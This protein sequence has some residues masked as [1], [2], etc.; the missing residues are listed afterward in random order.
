MSKRLYLL[1][2]ILAGLLISPLRGQTPT[3]SIEG[4]VTDPN[5]ANIAGATVTVTSTTTSKSV[6]VTTNDDGFFSVRS[7]EPGVY[8]IRVERAGFS[9]ATA[10]NIV[11][12]VSQVARA[13]IQL[14]VGTPTENVNVEVGATDIQV[15]TTRQTV[16]GVI[17]GRQITALPLNERNFLDLA[18]LQPGVTVLDG[19]VIDP[20]KV[21]AYRVVRVNGGSGT[22]TRVQLE[23]IDITDEVVGTT[24]ANLSTDAVQEFNLQ[25]SSFDLSTSLTTS[26]AVT[27]ATRTGGNKFSGSGFYFK[28]DDRF[29]AR[30]GFQAVKPKFNRDQTGYRFGGP[31][32][33]DRLFFFSNFERFNQQ[34]FNDFTSRNFPNFNSGATLPLVFRYALNRVDMNITKNLRAFYL[35]NYDDDVST[36][37][38]IRSPFQNVDWTNAHVVGANVSGTRMTHTFRF[39]YVNFNNRIESQELSQFPF[40]NVN[41]TPIQV[42]VGDLSYGPNSLAPQQTYQDTYQG[43]YDGSAVLGSHVLRYGGEISRIILGGFANFSG[44]V[45]VFGNLS[46]TTSTNPLLHTLDDFAVGPN[47]GF[48]TARPAHNLPFGGK[49]NTRYAFYGGD[50]WKMWPNFTVNFGLRWNY[51]TNFFSSPNVPRLPEIDVYGAGLGDAARY[52]KHAFSPQIGFAWDPWKDGKTSIRGGF[53]LA[54][55]S[56][57]FNNSLFDEFARITTGIGP[58]QLFSDFVVGP[59]GAPIV[60]PGVCPTTNTSGDYTC[61]LGQP[62]NAVLSQIV[63]INNA[64]QA[65]YN[66]SS[67]NPTA[68]PSEFRNT[69]GVTFGGQF[70]GDYKIPYSM[71]INIGFQRELIKGH[72]ISVDFIRQ[73]TV[74]LPLL[75]AD[76][77]ARRDARFFNE[78]AARTSIGTRIGVAPANVNPTTIQTFLNA[79]PNATITTFALANDTIWPGRTSLNTRARLAIGGF[80]EYRGMQI[81]MNGRFGRKTFNFLSMGERSL[82]HGLSYTVGYAFARNQA[83]S[84]VGR[85][86]FIANVTDNRDWNSD[87][88]PSGLDRKHNLTISAS[89][90]FIGGFR[91]D[92]IYRFATSAPQS[93][94]I[95]NTRGSSG[96]FTSDF[97]GDGGVGTTPR[98]DLLPGT[99]IGA[100]GRRIG[101]LEE[102]NNYIIAYNTNF[103]GR[104]TPH[105]Q[106]LVAAGIFSEAQLRALGAVLPTIPLVP[107]SNPNPFADLFTVDYRLTRPIKIW[108]ENWILEPSWSVFNVFNHV[109]LAQYGGL[110]TGTQFGTLNFPYTAA[111]LPLLTE[112]RGLRLENRRRQ[113]QFGIRFSF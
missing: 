69:G 65:A 45:T 5:K 15:D 21:N 106:R 4:V 70:P 3:G 28:Q 99:N 110:G 100:F 77:E 34:D 67:Y 27:I 79:N 44:P 10:E 76:Y 8:R 74:G 12:Q 30:P 60:V 50:T 19:G 17:T 33:K 72:V 86:E 51:D 42:N 96:I 2:L 52:P 7:L 97:N 91:L 68:G 95:P 64:V 18:V 94:F 54:Y 47:K 87:Y 82:F 38:T 88:G 105:G 89:L 57:I 29:D 73:R 55:E 92:Q 39:G 31:F 104:L 59:T 90:D 56:N 71:Q 108:K 46:S 11:V 103:A 78:A 1:L 35:H 49:F 85:P 32:I 37:G 101:S 111:D 40:V 24:V 22:G 62:I 107:L 83:T 93:L 80:S 58:T 36:G 41:G 112:S 48:F 16:D 75:L 84:G 66:I 43:K 81:S 61:L 6:T 98:G 14:K 13:D 25:R 53:Y 23:G 113:M 26:G 63:Q 102:L 109:A 20:T 9:T